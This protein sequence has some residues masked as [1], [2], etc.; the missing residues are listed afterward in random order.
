MRSAML[1][2]RPPY[3]STRAAYASASPA[4]H[5]LTT[6]WSVS[7]SEASAGPGQELGSF[8]LPARP[9]RCFAILGPLH[10]H[11]LARSRLLPYARPRRCRAGR[12]AR[13]QVWAR[14]PQDGGGDRDDLPRAPRTFE[15][16][17]GRGRARGAPGSRRVR[18]P[19][20][21]VTGIATF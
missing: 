9:G 1:N 15:S 20:V 7:V 12:P 18:G 2:T 11:D 4:R 19:E 3:R 8:G 6:S 14:H 21:L 17:I 5:A 16:Q 10:G 13:P